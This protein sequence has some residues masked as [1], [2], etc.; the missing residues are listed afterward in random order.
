MKVLCSCS[1]NLMRNNKLR[2]CDQLKTPPNGNEAKK[3]FGQ[4]GKR[5]VLFSL[6]SFFVCSTRDSRLWNCLACPLLF[7]QFAYPFRAAS[8]LKKSATTIAEGREIHSR[9]TNTTVNRNPMPA[10]EFRLGSQGVLVKTRRGFNTLL[11][12]LSD[13]LKR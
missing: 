4:L 13:P 7:K 5:N 8:I 3:I 1:N 2:C 11:A 9:H 6:V 10:Q 12:I